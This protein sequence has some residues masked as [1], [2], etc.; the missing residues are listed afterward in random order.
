MSSSEENT[1][2]QVLARRGLPGKIPNNSPG[3]FRGSQF[4]ELVTLEVGLPRITLADQAT[5]FI[6][7]NATNDAS[8]TLAGHADPELADADATMTKPFIHM[9]VSAASVK[10]IYLD[11]IEI[12][13]VTAPTTAAKDNWAAQL[14]TG[15]TR[16]TS[17]GTA[18]TKINP[19]MQSTATSD[20]TILGG[21][22]VTGAESPNAR[23]LGHGQNRAA[24]PIAGDRYLYRFG[25]APSSG[26]NVVGSAAS[27][28]LINM[29]PVIL[30]ATD[31]FL[32]AL[33]S[34]DDATAAA[35]VYK[36]RAA[37][38]EY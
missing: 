13:I 6:A 3:P 29:P 37:W 19:N 33:Y 32:L 2:P 9:L 12:E 1:T 25:G 15:A 31:Q 17:G 34:A 8:S 36:V 4:G 14:D 24:I 11:Y 21:A 26:D 27:R 35:G 20:L 23:H 10:R 30:G 5:Y 38:W 28:H 18:L 16:V 22:V 7:H